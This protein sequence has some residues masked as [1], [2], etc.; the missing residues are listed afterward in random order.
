MKHPFV[1]LETGLEQCY[2]QCLLLMRKWKVYVFIFCWLNRF[3]HIS[4]Y[5][6]NKIMLAYSE[7]Y[8]ASGNEVFV[9]DISEELGALQWRH[10]GRDSVS[11]LQPHDCLLNRLFRRRSKK[12]SK[13][14]VTGLCAMNSPGTGEFLPQMASYYAGNVSIWWRHHGVDIC[15]NGSYS[16]NMTCRLAAIAVLLP[17]IL[18]Y[19]QLIIH[20]TRHWFR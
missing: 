10:N 19:D 3:I 15:I 16:V 17:C 13:L 20:V 18:L 4:L 2:H 9:V 12:T 5:S 11:N 14:R 6:P 1:R 8:I 7:V